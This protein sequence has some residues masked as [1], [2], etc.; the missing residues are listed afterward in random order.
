MTIVLGPLYFLLLG[1]IEWT[2][3]YLVALFMFRDWFNVELFTYGHVVFGLLAP[4]L[5]SISLKMRGYKRSSREE[6]RGRFP[7]IRTLW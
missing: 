5:V 2:I 4:G 3:F 6:V 7:L 1:A